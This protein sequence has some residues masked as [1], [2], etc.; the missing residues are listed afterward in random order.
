VPRP[1]P[2]PDLERWL[3]RAII[4]ER[5][6]GPVRLVDY[7]PEWP[8]RFARIRERLAGALG[9]TARTIEHIGSTAVPGI[10][11]KPIIDVLVTVDE[12]EDEARYLP[13]IVELGYELRVRED[14]HRMFRPASRDAHVH[15]CAEGGREQHDY[16]LLRDWL[17]HSA[18]D[19]GAYAGL[20]RK[21]AIEDWPDV[22][23]Y[24]RAK[25]PLISEILA[26][27]RADAGAGTPAGPRPPARGRP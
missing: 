8:A 12:V 3:D 11:A 4:G 23:Y 24:A 26:R 15:V 21:L 19:R 10:E 20:K 16:L 13:A 7:D 5:Q 6:P 22:N 2:D 27:A 1:S 25:S 9:A 18:E 14:R 17:R